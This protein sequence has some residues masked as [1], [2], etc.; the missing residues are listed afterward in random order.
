MN[1]QMQPLYYSKKSFII[2]LIISV[3]YFAI[4]IGV[5][6]LY[7]NSL[8]KKSL[9]IQLNLQE[10]ISDGSRSFF[11]FISQIGTITVFM[12]FLIIL[13]LFYPINKPFLLLSLIIH[14]SFWD[15]LMKIIYGN[16]RPYWDDMQLSA[17]CNGG[18]GNPSGH[19]FSSVA[20][21]LG[22]SYALTDLEF[23]HKR[24]F[25]KI[26]VYL[27]LSILTILIIFSRII[28]N[29]HSINQVLYGG[30]L[31]L[32][33]FFVYCFVFNL[34]K[35]KAKAFL[36]IF[37]NTTLNVVF[38]ILYSCMLTAVI[39][40]YYKIDNYKF[41]YVAL[42]ALKCESKNNYRMF[43]PDGLFNALSLFGL[44][45]AHVGMIFLTSY[46]N[47]YFPN[48]FDAIYN[49]SWNKQSY[50]YFFIKIVMSAIAFTPMSLYFIIPGNSDLGVIF[51]F[52]V[53]IP[54]CVTGFL[55]FGP[56]IWL[57]IYKKCANFEIY[58]MDNAYDIS[59]DTS[60]RNKIGSNS[61]LELKQIRENS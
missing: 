30:L 16:P 23:F 55:I 12:P 41:E 38:F 60:N 52:K 27:F 2:K 61:N 47:K 34:N 35:I 54:Y 22:L 51:V 17:S 13:Y 48:K 25:F 59:V 37:R 6:S 28:L 5:E 7:R 56:C 21:Y 20:V 49:W 4:I 18:F 45:G 43:N 10:N 46:T 39:L 53:S 42:M 11:E 50:K 44:I 9:E 24:R 29:A 8:Y 36:R 40:C 1:H 57:F 15:N 32:G 33:L 26:L 58:Y 14:S 3:I 19:A 31:G